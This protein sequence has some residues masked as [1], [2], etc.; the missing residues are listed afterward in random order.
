MSL[1]VCVTKL[2]L[3]YALVPLTVKSTD[4]TGN[5]KLNILSILFRFDLLITF[6][7]RRTRKN[8]IWPSA[9]GAATQVN[10]AQTTP[11]RIRH[12]NSTGRWT[13][14]QKVRTVWIGWDKA[15]IYCTYFYWFNFWSLNKILYEII[16]IVRS[17]LEHCFV[18][19]LIQ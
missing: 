13:N 8:K 11:I 10:L 15:F 7:H 14:G 4:F 12:A 18:S 17:I 9:K 1:Y 19:Y 5:A 16:C 6:A 3:A 2:H